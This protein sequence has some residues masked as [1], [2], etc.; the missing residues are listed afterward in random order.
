M[1]EDIFE[2]G[3]QSAAL[4][5]NALGSAGSRLGTTLGTGDLRRKYNFGERVSELALS[6]DPFFRFVS[7]VN[8]Q[9]TDDPAFKFTEKR[10]SWHKRYAYV[11]KGG[12][13]YTTAQGTDIDLNAD[14]GSAI[15]LQMGTDYASA[16]NNTAIGYKAFY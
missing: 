2:N 3:L 6:Q 4:G 11:H 16:G 8:K 13:T 5:D 15:Q 14:Q 12:A 1:A 7:K 9:G 10:G